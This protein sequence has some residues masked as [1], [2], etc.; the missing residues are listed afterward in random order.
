MK[1]VGSIARLLR[2]IRFEVLDT[3]GT[4]RLTFDAVSQTWFGTGSPFTGHGVEYREPAWTDPDQSAGLA[5]G[6]TSAQVQNPGALLWTQAAPANRAVVYT[7]ATATQ[8]ASV[9]LGTQNAT[10]S[11][12]ANVLIY[13]DVANNTAIISLQAASAAGQSSIDMADGNMTISANNPGENLTVFGSMIV[14]PSTVLTGIR[15][16]AGRYQLDNA[17]YVNTTEMALVGT[18]PLTFVTYGGG[19]FMQDTTWIRAVNNK[20]IYTAGT[21]RADAEAYFPVVRFSA[22]DTDNGVSY[23]TTNTWQLFAAGTT[24]AYVDVNGFHV[25]GNVGKQIRLY[26]HNDPN[27][28]IYYWSAA[29]ATVHPLSGIGA[30]GP[31]VIGFSSVVLSTVAGGRNWL[32]E[33][34]GSAFGPGGWLTFSSRRGKTR[35]VTI[36][37]SDAYRE[38]MAWRPVVYSPKGEPG[39]RADGVIA[40]ELIEVS[41]NLV[42]APDGVP[43]AVD[44]GRMVVRLAAAVQH[45]AGEVDQLRKLLKSRA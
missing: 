5:F 34:G 1:A 40:E 3:S 33:S 2:A 31:R 30:N 12:R 37:P 9:F 25:F 13:S 28:A 32:F 35:V 42:A 29:P 17:W 26:A 24:I 11:N 43:S 7:Q 44:Y 23:I 6:S 27:H 19:W 18:R 8:F 41:P 4:V 36:K 14:T 20:S 38:V 22:T 10:A 16:T 15:L 39:I 21:M 45:L